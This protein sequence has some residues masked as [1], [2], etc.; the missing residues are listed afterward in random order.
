MDLARRYTDSIAP[1]SF[2]NHSQLG[3]APNAKTVG[4][5]L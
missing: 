4:K 1:V 5:A 2:S 3:R